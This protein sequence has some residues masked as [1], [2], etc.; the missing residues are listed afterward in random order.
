MARTAGTRA[1]ILTARPTPSQFNVVVN[2]AFVNV[3]F[4]ASALRAREVVDTKNQKNKFNL[5]VLDQLAH[6]FF[7]TTCLKVVV[8]SN[9]LARILA[10]LAGSCLPWKARTDV[11]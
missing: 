4:A 5:V 10:E 11:L 2:V 3:T 7:L 6:L 1:L 9:T 8:K